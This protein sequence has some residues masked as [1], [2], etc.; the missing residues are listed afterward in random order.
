VPRFVVASAL[1]VTAA[2][3][4]TASGEQARPTFRAGVEVVRLS[5]LVQ[6]KDAPVVGLRAEDFEVRDNGVRQRIERITH[7]DLPLQLVLA[8]DVSG[9]V[10]GEKLVALKRASERA[11]DGLRAGD[12]AGLLTFTD[13]VRQVVPLGGEIGL[14]RHGVQGLEAEGGT[15]LVDGT[16]AA[17]VLG[18][19]AAGRTLAIVFTDGGETVSFLPESA[20]V[21]A[22]RRTNVVV[23]GVRVHERT[24]SFLRRIASA[25]GGRVLDAG[26]RDLADTFAAILDEFRTRYVL[27]YT[28]SGVGRKGW[29]RV[30]V[31]VKD[32]SATVTV[33]D[34]YAVP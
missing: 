12:R 10:R 33:R 25:T 8:L 32:R 15:A 17:I 22:A 27:S 30:A 19:G 29:H 14:L 28:P 24:T 4:A 21:D 26:A 1:I 5:V 11:L 6:G 31:R 23:Y 34:G 9:S 13:T 16:L 7:E 3:T 18:D 20:A 2:A